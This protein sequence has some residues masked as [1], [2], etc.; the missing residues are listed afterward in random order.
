M[1]NEGV[2]EGD[3]FTQRHSD[4]SPNPI[5]RADGICD[6]DAFRTSSYAPARLA[7]ANLHSPR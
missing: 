5:P 7:R 1:S 4:R 6:L 3:R 2:V